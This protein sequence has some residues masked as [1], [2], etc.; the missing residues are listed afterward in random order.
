M[1]RHQPNEYRKG[2]RSYGNVDYYEGFVLPGGQDPA[3]R[4]RPQAIHFGRR[5]Y[6]VSRYFGHEGTQEVAR[7]GNRCSSRQR[8][9]SPRKLEIQCCII[10]RNGNMV[11]ERR[12]QEGGRAKGCIFVH[13]LYFLLSPVFISGF[14]FSFSPF[15][16]YQIWREDG[17]VWL[18]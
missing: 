2:S 9:Q 17:V 16:W 4:P 1:G 18:L 14:A 11:Y 5:G 10:V 7:G 8:E 13:I 15:R 6:R 12:K 3:G